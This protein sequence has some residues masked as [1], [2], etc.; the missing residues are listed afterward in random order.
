MEQTN[1]NPKI[2]LDTS[3]TLSKEQIAYFKSRGLSEEEIAIIRNAH[4]IANETDLIPDDPTEAIN[5]IENLP[6]DPSKAL[7]AFLEMGE[8]DPEA[9]VECVA[10]VDAMDRAIANL[11]RDTKK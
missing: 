2:E 1:N 7:Q 3:D 5:R 4:A 6:D 10:V 8:K 11:P 9:F